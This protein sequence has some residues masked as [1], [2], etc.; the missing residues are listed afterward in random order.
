[1]ASIFKVTW[2][3]KV[4]AGIPV[5]MSTLQ[6]A[7]KRKPLQRAFL[8]DSTYCLDLAMWPAVV[9]EAGILAFL[10]KWR[11]CTKGDGRTDTW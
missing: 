10:I 2:Y 1:M 5:I 9:S 8:E 6:E 7:E 3:S 11:L 4:H